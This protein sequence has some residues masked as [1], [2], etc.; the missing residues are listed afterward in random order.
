MGLVPL[1]LR[2]LEHFI[3]VA[4]DRSFTAAATRLHLSQ[5]AL[6]D[7]IRR[8]ERELG[9]TLLTRTTRRVALTEPGRALLTDARSLVAAALAARERVRR[10]DRGD[11]PVLRVGHTP[12]LSGEQVHELTAPLLDRVPD[13]RFAATQ[14][15]PSDLLDE[16]A[17]GTLDLG[18]ARALAAPAGLEG[19]IVAEHALRVALHRDHP[20]AG[21]ERVALGDLAE[22][23]LIVWGDPGRSNHADELIERCRAA[24]FTPRTVRS[25]MQGTPP[26][27]SV[28]A[29]DRF[30]LVTDRPGPAVGGRVLVRELDP[31]ARTAVRALWNPAATPPLVTTWLEALPPAT[32]EK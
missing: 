20:L 26:V 2:K 3:A 28:V 17:R 16:L 7:S 25:A 11:H 30:A 24:G 29:P 1:D 13:V 21:R 15:Y 10:V 32:H 9:V 8:L 18:L 22:D 19:R 4:E 6:S 14:R 27:T 5:Q 12:A 23:R 31:P